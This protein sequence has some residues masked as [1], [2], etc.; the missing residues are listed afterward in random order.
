MLLFSYGLS[1]SVAG[2]HI[3][4]LCKLFLLFQFNWY[5]KRVSLAALYKA[6]EVYMVQD[7]SE[8]FMNTW[9]FL[10]RRMEDL[11]NVGK[12][13]RSVRTE[14]IQIGYISWLL[15]NS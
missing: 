14:L 11:G 9:N 7:K 4:T 5:T 13:A 6:T 10:D 3:V 1:S 15:L 8:D 2:F 12:L